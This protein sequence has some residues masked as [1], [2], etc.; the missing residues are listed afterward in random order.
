MEFILAVTPSLTT[1][2]EGDTE[3]DPSAFQ[4][5][6]DISWII[7]SQGQRIIDK[8]HGQLWRFQKPERNWRSV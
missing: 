8:K 3:D 4:E 1:H 2:I 6:S 5:V 7:L